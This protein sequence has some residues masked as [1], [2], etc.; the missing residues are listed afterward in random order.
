MLS[1]IVFLCVLLTLSGFALTL[2]LSPLTAD[3]NTAVNARE[4]EEPGIFGPRGAF[5]LANGFYTCAFAAGAMIGPLCSGLIK[6]YFG[7]I[8]MCWTLSALS[9]FTVPFI[10]LWVGG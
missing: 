9:L 10:F 3:L 5:A 7:W 4:A 1:H 8:V 6:A 2:I